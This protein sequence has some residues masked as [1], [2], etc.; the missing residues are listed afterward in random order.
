MT[1]DA[2]ATAAATPQLTWKLVALVGLAVFSLTQMREVVTMTT[3]EGKN[4]RETTILCERSAPRD[5]VAGAVPGDSSNASHQAPIR[6][7]EHEMISYDHY[8]PASTEDYVMKHT[9]ELGYADVNNPPGCNIWKNA[10]LTPIHGDLQ[11]F[12]KELED[13]SAKMTAFP[14]VQKDLR[15]QIEDN[16]SQQEEICQALEL[17]PH[18]LPA[19]FPSGQLSLTR[20]GYVEPLLTPMRHPALCLDR[21]RLMDM[22]Y[23]I[24][25]FAA[26]CRRLKPDSRTI[27]VDMGASLDF[28]AGLESP[29]MYVTK[30]FGKFGFVFDHIYAFEVVEKKPTAVYERVPDE[31]LAS[32]HWINVGVNP[33]PGHRFNP[34]SSILKKFTKDDFV[35]VKLDVDTASVEIPLA[36][37]V[38]EDP[39]LNDI[40]DQFYFEHHVHLGELAPNWRHTM[41]GTVEESLKLFSALR[42][43]GVAAHFWP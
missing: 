25:D 19:M 32:Y 3:I 13:Y 12:L 29:A 1:K 34:L 33:T 28:H 35:V 18:G 17:H 42:E 24:H 10:E 40:I 4:L 26:M 43:K 8:I 21:N 6:A 7:G 11:A 41:Q 27:F 31:F 2:A 16:P 22:K 5:T 23:L 37:Q 15:L 9:Q 36:K 30:T 14:D 20:S 39:E 38:L